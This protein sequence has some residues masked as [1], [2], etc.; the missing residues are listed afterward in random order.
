M[1]MRMLEAGGIP[2]LTDG[3]RQADADNPNGYYEW[4]RAKRVK[5]DRSWLRDARGKAVKMVYLLLYDLPADY[6][7]RVLFMERTLQEVIASQHTMLRRQGKHGHV[8]DA[9]ELQRV[10]VAHLHRVKSWLGAQPSFKVRY[11]DYG[12]IVRDPAAAAKD[13]ATFLGRFLDTKAMSQVCE[14]TLYR[15]RAD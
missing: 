3:L 15:Q 2:P 6:E 10:Y 9:A 5:E 13:I 8:M 12:Q 11:C 4:E 1:M 14:P 7:Y